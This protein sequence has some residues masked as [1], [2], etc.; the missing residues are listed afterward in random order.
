LVE[1][2]MLKLDAEIVFSV[3]MHTGEGPDHEG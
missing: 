2:A 3:R 1:I